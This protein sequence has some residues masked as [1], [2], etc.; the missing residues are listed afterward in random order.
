MAAEDKDDSVWPRFVLITGLS[1]AG[2]TEALR[3]FEDMGYYCIDNLP[4]ALIQQVAELSFQKGAASRP[5]A[6]VID[7]RGGAFF[8][9]ALQA[10]DA[11]QAAGIGCHILF[12]EAD[13]STLVRRY[14]E[15]RRQHPLAPGGRVVDGIKA[16]RLRLADL[17][18]RAHRV[19]DTSSFNRRRLR[20]KL[21]ALYAGTRSTTR[22]PAITLVSF[23]FKRGL[24]LDSDLVFDARWLPNPHYVTHL[25][26]QT[27]LD[28]DVRAYVL[29][30]AMAGQFIE[31]LADYINF[32]LPLYASDGREHLTVAI[33]CTGGRHRSVAIAEVLAERLAGDGIKPRVTHRDIGVAEHEVAAAQDGEQAAR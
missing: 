32:M 33:G 1:G 22:T 4:P 20:S 26:P 8:D 28:P 23:G 24:P 16:E 5:V 29:Q 13:E 2:R 11:L 17:R 3:C 7:I 25:R 14:Q 10:I 15:T 31:R 27:G 12:L 21:Q 18:A 19:I 30:P 9:T 6:I